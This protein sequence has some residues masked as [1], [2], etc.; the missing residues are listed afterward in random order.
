MS[1]ASGAA[2]QPRLGAARRL[3]VA[4]LVNFVAIG[5][6]IAAI[7]RY[8]TEELGAGKGLAG[9]ATTSFF[10][11]AA[12]WRPVVGRLLDRRGR[13]PF[14][15]WPLAALSLLGLTLLGA[16]SVAAVVG[17]RVLQGLSGTSF[18]TA[19]AAAVTDLAPADRQ[20]S[21]LARLSLSIYLGLATGPALGELLFDQ[22]PGWAWATMAVLHGVALLVAVGLPETR[23][24]VALPEPPTGAPAASA[25]GPAPP[26]GA[27]E[28]SG[29]GTAVWRAVLLPGLV[30]LTVGVAYASITAFLPLYARE[31]GLGSSG[32]LYATF[33]LTVLG[34]RTVAGRLADRYGFLTVVVPGLAATASGLAL[35]ALVPEPAAAFVGVAVTA[36]GI[37]VIFPALAALTVGRVDPGR[38]GAALGAFL[39]YNDIGNGIGG[40]LVGVTAEA[41]GFQWG[42]ALPAV[43]VSAS[44]V[45]TVAR[46]GWTARLATREVPAEPVPPG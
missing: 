10:L 35:L 39:A 5:I 29:A 36:A 41:F 33:A 30:L 26:P 37:A 14:L 38:R 3:D 17:I 42:Y 11:V 2:A 20:A 18:Y 9:L 24:P 46:R 16:S 8:V 28:A 32:A 40:P 23:Q 7:P 31:I 34:V 12:L 15:V 4:V 6:S 22:G 43:L 21:A 27:A 1:T 45:G 25:T 44:L 13:R 19:A